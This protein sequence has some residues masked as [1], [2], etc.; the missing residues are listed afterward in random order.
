MNQLLQ[1]LVSSYVL[2]HRD[3]VDPWSALLLYVDGVYVADGYSFTPNDVISIH[4][5]SWP[6]GV[7]SVDIHLS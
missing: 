3:E 1:A 6:D 4:A 7:E 2:L 5:Y